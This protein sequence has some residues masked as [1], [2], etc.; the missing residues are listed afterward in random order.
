M[1]PEVDSNGGLAELISS[2]STVICCGSGG[3]GKTTVAAAIGLAGA[4]AGRRVCVVTIDPARRLADALGLAEL[5]NAPVRIESA[6]GN[7]PGELWAV[8]LDTKR[9]FDDLI[10][11]HSSD[12]AQVEAI[13]QNRIY[14]NLSGSLSGTQEY[15]AMEKLYEL[16]TDDRFDLVVVDT[17]PTRNAL[18]FLDAPRQL[19]RFLDNRIFRLLMMPARTYLRAVSV[20]TRTFLRTISRVVGREAVADAVAFFQAFEGLE[21]GFRDRAS[22]VESVLSDPSTAFVLVTSPRRE[23]AEE[24]MF[25]ATKLRSSR[26]TVAALVVNRVHPGFEVPADSEQKLAKLAVTG[27]GP[28]AALASNWVEMHRVAQEER[29]HLVSLRDQIA[30]APVVEVPL[31]QGDV[32][33]MG[34]VAAVA[35][36]LTGG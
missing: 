10:R 33:D 23:A 31:L 19:G 30:P 34:G 4:R 8:M 32:H 3:V 24:A 7:G 12:P 21:Q 36:H 2:R 29:S 11:N 35:S 28:I 9:T 13:F 1:G 17:P 18:D 26:M 25:F 22:K 16:H 6:T 27:V 15:M 5:H 14:Q 20:A